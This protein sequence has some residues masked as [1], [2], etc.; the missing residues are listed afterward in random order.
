M[1]NIHWEA[2]KEFYQKEFGI[3]DWVVEMYANM[4]ILSLSVSGVS[5]EG[6]VNFLELP[7]KEVEKV[8]EDVF[9]FGGWN[10]D[11]PINPYRLW[12]LYDGKRNSVEHFHDFVSD[13]GV[14][15]GKYSGFESVKAEK[16]FYMCETYNDIEERINNEWV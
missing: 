10:K 6:I 3:E 4:D 9:E 13:I 12:K 14:E 11:L 5:N 2:V 16:L 15:L 1:N 8:L 7:M